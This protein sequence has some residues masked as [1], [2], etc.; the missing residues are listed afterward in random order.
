[1]LE[2]KRLKK[3]RR[4]FLALT[5][6]TPKEF[7]LLL[8]AFC[9]VYESV[10]SGD[11]TQSGRVRQRYV[12]GGRKERLGSPEQKLLFI[13]V[14]QKAYPL[15]TLL[16]EVF[17]LS[18]ARVN[19][20][21]HHL[22]PLLQQTLGALELLPER[23]P[24]QF[25]QH[26]RAKKEPPELIIDGTDRRRQRPKNQAKQALHYSG[27]QKTH[28]D[29]NIVVVNA[30]TKRVG[31]LSPTYAGK[32]HDKKIVDQEAIAYPRDAILYKDTGFQGY[33]PPVRQ[34]RQPK[35]SPAK[36]PC[37]GARSGII[38]RCRGSG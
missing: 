20:W 5:G 4:K 21:V 19:Y 23:E 11:I 31:Y 29:K 26:E 32:T 2:Y 33:E 15:Q 7:Q 10:H 36:E 9:E 1:V 37:P 28:S 18:Q 8:P 22:L 3:H 34:T 6:L 27:K 12:G 35:K 25:A 24:R 17:E 16:G 30:K 38:G 14:Y 13:L